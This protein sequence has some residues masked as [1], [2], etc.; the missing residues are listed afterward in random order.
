MTFDATRI[1][2]ALARSGASWG[3]PLVFARET[4][5]TNDDAKI[6]ARSGAPSGAAFWADAQTSGRGRLGRRWHSPPGENLYVSFVFRPSF[7]LSL[8]PLVTLAAGLAVVD[9]VEPLV[10]QCAPMIK[11]PNDVLVRDRKLA[12]ILTEGQLGEDRGPWIVIG[13][14]INVTTASFPPEAGRATS[15]A[16]AGAASLDR[17]DLFVSLALS[18]ASRIGRLGEAGPRD[19]VAELARRDALFGRAISID[20]RPAAAC[21][22]AE[23]GRLRVR[24]AD[25]TETACVA[26]D[27]QL[28][29]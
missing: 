2:E 22:I 25:G 5:S 1:E 27:V 10:S 12:G 24:Y 7:D 17:S 18:L 19:T 13:V 20:G 3:R 21:G 26:G 23:D 11:W 9:A 29:L 28:R 8:A 4:G 14:G 15:L 6:A 16:L